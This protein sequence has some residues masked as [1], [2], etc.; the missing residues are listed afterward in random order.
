MS[1]DFQTP[2]LRLGL[3][4]QSLAKGC[5]NSQI[6]ASSSFSSS[7]SKTL[8]RS[9]TRT[10]TRTRR[11]RVPLLSQQ[12]LA[13]PL[14]IH[15]WSDGG[16]ALWRDQDLL[17]AALSGRS[18]LCSICFLRFSPQPVHSPQNANRNEKVLTRSPGFAGS[19]P[20]QRFV[21]AGLGL[22]R[23]SPGQPVGAGV[24][25][26]ELSVFRARADRR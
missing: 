25:A 20:T 11:W 22:R 4:F 23:P 1:P 2:T 17:S 26:D 21:R 13:S 7:S 3:Q 5:C 14:A 10:R 19:A 16:R 12:A 9:R 8:R 18:A 15:Q 6:R 24:T